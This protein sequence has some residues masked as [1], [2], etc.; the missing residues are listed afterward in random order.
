MYRV[1][2]RVFFIFMCVIPVS[3]ALSFDKQKPLDVTS[4]NALIY[5]AANTG[6]Y[7]GHVIATQGT[8]QL[9]AEQ[10]TAELDQTNQLVRLVAIGTEA[11]P[12]RFVTL[13]H[14]RDQP[15]VAHAQKIIYTPINN[16]VRL[17]GD[18]TVTHAKDSYHAQLIDYDTLTQ[19]VKTPRNTGGATIIIHPKS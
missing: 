6:I 3:A 10:V 16:Q 11:V 8:T 19:T 18:A 17:S 7:R 1:L 2:S 12:A 13:P 9:T 14:R 4:D 15:V 5:I